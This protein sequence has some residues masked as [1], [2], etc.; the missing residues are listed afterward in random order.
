MS[1]EFT[2]C[3]H[4]NFSCLSHVLLIIGIDILLKTGGGHEIRIL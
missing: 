1:L 2:Y 4:F 3:N